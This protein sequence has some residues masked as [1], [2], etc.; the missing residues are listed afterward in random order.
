MKGWRTI[1]VGIIIGLVIL[2]GYVYTSRTQSH[3]PEIDTTRAQILAYLGDLDCYSYI[4]NVTTTAE[5]RT[6]ES[7]IEG[8]KI[9]G[10]YYFQGE[11]KGLI[12]HAVILNNTL[13][14]RISIN[15]TTREVNL[16]L[17]ADEKALFLSADPV[18]IA[19]QAVGAGKLV[20]K[21]KDSRVY[22]FNILVSPSTNVRM[23][24]TVTVFWD[25]E[26]VTKLIF[27]VKV[28]TTD[29]QTEKRTI[30]AAIREKCEQT[31]WAKELTG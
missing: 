28:R 4:E 18:K 26:K 17:S 1:V 25:G 6:V 8:G 24:G 3:S 12:W 15:G 19:L 27:N 11:S 22:S 21:D 7:N 16:T 9:N 2:G 30:T 29:G 23:N 10:T 14:E 13:L 5:N 20:R 31:E